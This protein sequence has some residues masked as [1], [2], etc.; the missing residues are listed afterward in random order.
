MVNNICIGLECISK[1]KRNSKLKIFLQI[2]LTLWS[3]FI[4]YMTLSLMLGLKITNES[5]ISLSIAIL[6]IILTGY[7]ALN[8]SSYQAH[9]DYN[10]DHIK[11]KIYDIEA[12]NKKI[13]QKLDSFYI[14]NSFE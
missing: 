6:S 4:V 11:S 5:L 14:D 3:L 2:I 10:I 9:Y 12:D 7:I 1:L 13:L 8:D